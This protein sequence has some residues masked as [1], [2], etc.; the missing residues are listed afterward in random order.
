MAM[1]MGMSFNPGAQTRQ[2]GEAPTGGAGQTPIQDAIRTLSLRIP[3][4]RG[5]GLAPQPLMASPGASGVMGGGMMGGGMPGG[6]QQLLQQIFGQMGGGAGAQAPS[7]SSVPLPNFTPGGGGAL[8]P[9]GDFAP[10]SYQPPAP[11]QQPPADS[12]HYFP[13][14]WPDQQQTGYRR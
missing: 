2:P 8:Q 5:P 9:P 10:G 14:N 1:D 6:L 11:P 12:G 3:H 7:A 4:F 13:G